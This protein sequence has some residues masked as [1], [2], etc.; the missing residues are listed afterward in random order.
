MDKTG[1]GLWE[2][3]LN[4]GQPYWSKQTRI[5]FGISEHEEINAEST[6]QR[7]HPDDIFRVNEMLGDLV[8]Q[9]IPQYQSIYRTVP[10]DGEIRYHEGKAIWS[11]TRHYTTKRI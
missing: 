7:V 8:T 4:T 6:A 11:Y 9:R 5:M 10:I 3:D 1:I 2:I